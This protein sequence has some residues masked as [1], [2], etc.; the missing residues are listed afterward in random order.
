MLKDT[1]HGREH[2]AEA[3]QQQVEPAVD[4]ASTESTKFSN[5]GAVPDV[6][7]GTGEH[8]ATA[9]DQAYEHAPA[10]KHGAGVRVLRYML[11]HQADATPS[12]VAKVLGD[13]P[14]DHHAMLALL[15]EKRDA[16]FVEEVTHGKKAAAP[17]E[18]AI[19]PAQA[20]IAAAPAPTTGEEKVAEAVAEP[21]K[22]ETPTTSPA[23]EAAASHTGEA[24]EVHKDKDKTDYKDK[25]WAEKRGYDKLNSHQQDMIDSLEPGQGEKIWDQLDAKH[26]AGFLNVTAVMRS[27]GFLVAGLKLRPLTADDNSGIQQDRLLFTADTGHLLQAPLEAAI[28]QRETRGDKGFIE[29]KPENSLHPGMAGWGGRQWCTRF[30]MQVG[31]G[32]GG[33]FVDIDEFGPK[34]DVVGTMGHM[35]EVLR[36]KTQHV[37]TDP[38]TVAKGLHKRGDDP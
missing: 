6:A 14:A 29:D 26:R 2:T 21:T 19:E 34:V 36:N 18:P 5:D 28:E 37:K 13:F 10:P 23:A 20:P 7:H 15:H 30:S 25:A 27:N 17:V 8:P 22:A 12:M 11:D 16:T 32:A 1:H 3:P 9:S 24:V 31:G 4:T 38:N 33:A 35:F